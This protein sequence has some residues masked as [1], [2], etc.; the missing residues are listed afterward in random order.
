MRTISIEVTKN[1]ECHD[2]ANTGVDFVDLAPGKSKN[3]SLLKPCRPRTAS[4]FGT[5]FNSPLAYD[6]PPRGQI[7]KEQSGQL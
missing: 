6:V 2:I 4:A 5:C 1:S 7:I 3:Y